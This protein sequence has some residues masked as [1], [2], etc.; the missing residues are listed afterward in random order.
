MR[1]FLF[2]QRH[3]FLLPAQFVA[4]KSSYLFLY[5]RDPGQPESHKEA[6]VSG[7]H[8]SDD[9]A[10]IRLRPQPS[11]P[12]FPSTRRSYEDLSESVGPG[13]AD[14][15]LGRVER[16]VVDG[17]LALLAVSRELLHARL[18]LQIPQADGAVVTWG[19]EQKKGV[20]GLGVGGGNPS[21]TGTGGCCRALAVARSR[22]QLV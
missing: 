9:M 8:Q 2:L 3:H 15:A 19:R 13:A 4:S 11:T 12:E 1:H 22:F 17:L 5:S 7:K 21:I 18:A 14:V 16:H 6:E 20:W 10:G